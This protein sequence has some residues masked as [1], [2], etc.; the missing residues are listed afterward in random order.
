MTPRR[1]LLMRQAA[2]QHDRRLPENEEGVAQIL[3]QLALVL[4]QAAAEGASATAHRAP[5]AAPRRVR[6]SRLRRAARPRP[7]SRPSADGAARRRAPR[8][9]A[10]LCRRC[11]IAGMPSRCPSEA[12]CGLHPTVTQSRHALGHSRVASPCGRRRRRQPTACAP[13]TSL[14]ASVAHGLRRHRVDA[15]DQLGVSI[16]RSNS[17]SWRA[18]CSARAEEL[19]SPISRPALSCALERASSAS[20]GL[21]VGGALQLRADDVDQLAHHL[22]PRCRVDAEQPRIGQRP[23]ARIDRIAEAAPLPHLLEQ[24]G[25]H[26][27]AEQPREH[28]GRV[29]LLVAVRRARQSHHE[30]ALLERLRRGARAPDIPRRL[31][32]PRRR[33][34]SGRRIGPQRGARA[35]RGRRCRRP[36]AP[37]ALAP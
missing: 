16:S 36:T 30:M 37:C 12:C 2:E 11:W 17:S 21:L 26:A 34:H 25:R 27:P 10:C 1:T 28:L 18:I 22:R 35:R 9:S 4:A 8:M 32:S 14:A 31:E 20:A 15:L 7:R 6:C 19:S 33:R 5:I 3:A 24:P 29:E 23:A 13:P